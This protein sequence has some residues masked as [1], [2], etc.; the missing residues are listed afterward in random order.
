MTIQGDLIGALEAYAGS[1]VV[2]LKWFFGEQLEDAL[3]GAAP[4]LSGTVGGVLSNLLSLG[5]A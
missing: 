2:L 3:K 5:A 4:A 1:L